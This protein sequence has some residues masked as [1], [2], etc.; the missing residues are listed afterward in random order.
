MAGVIPDPALRDELDQ[1]VAAKRRG[2][3]QDSFTP[4]PL[5]SAF[6][7]RELRRFEQGPPSFATE[8]QQTD[9]DAVCKAVLVDAWPD[10]N[11]PKRNQL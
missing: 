3:E 7:E 6:V 5:V 9:L 10:S 8:Q 2:A 11:V 4:S 1:L